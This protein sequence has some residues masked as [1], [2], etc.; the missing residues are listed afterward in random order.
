MIFPWQKWK[1]LAYTDDLTGLW[2][3]RYLFSSEWENKRYKYLYF[4]DAN[5]L[6]EVNKQEGFLA[7]DRV[8]RD[9]ADKLREYAF[10]SVICRIGG[11]EF[12][13]LSDISVLDELPRVINAT[14]VMKSMS[15]V[16]P[17]ALIIQE[18]SLECVRKKN[19]ASQHGNIFEA[20]N[21]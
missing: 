19:E 11:D 2:N 18:A 4:V 7:G 21:V 6:G 1:R 3:R 17:L 15:G 20:A 12:V 14:V 10:N 8:L 16:K 9:I 13:I 5:D